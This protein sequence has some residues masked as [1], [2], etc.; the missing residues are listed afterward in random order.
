[1]LFTPKNFSHCI[2]DFVINQIKIQEV[3]ETKFLGVIID[4]KLKWSAHIMYINKKIAKGIGILLK[5]RKVFDNDTLL[6]LYHTF[7]YPYLHYCIH[8]WGKAYNTHPNDLVVLQ[9]KAMGIIGGVPPITNM[10]RFYV[11]MSILTV[12]HIYNY[13]IGLFMYKYVNKMTPDVFDN[14]FRNMSDIHLHNTRNATQKQF[15]ITYRGTTRVQK[16]FS[17]CGPHIRNFII[18]TVIQ[19][20]QLAHSKKMSRQLFL[21]ANDDVI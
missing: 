14:F 5:S 3:K 13:N 12:K 18:K 2:D 9:N 8:V 21:V 1:M 19:T 15:Y 4:S 10:D 7:V 6:S 17:Y 16:T 11:E 20:A